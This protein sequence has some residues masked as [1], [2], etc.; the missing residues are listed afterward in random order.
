MKKLFLS[1]LCILNFAGLIA[2]REYKISSATELSALQL[3]AGDKVILANVEWKDQ[4]LILTGNG[5]EASPIV[6]VMEKPGITR[7]TGSS[8]LLIDGTWLQAD[9]LYFTDGYSNKEDVVV[10]SNKSSHC[11]LTNTAI[12]NYFPPDLK[13]DNRWVSLNGQYNRVDHCWLEGKSNQGPTLVVWLA[14]QPNYHRIDHNYFGTRQE[15]GQNGGETIRIGTSGW[16]MHDSYTTVEDNI[17]YHCDGEI[18]AI[19][20]KSCKNTLRNNLFYECKATLTLRHGNDAEVYGNFFI[21]NNKPGTGGIRIIGE[22]HK[23]HDNYLQDLTG[24]NVSAAINI[25]DGLPNP[26][27]TS[28]WQVKNAVI[29]KN[30]IINC[31][32]SFCIGSGKN[33]ERYL[34]ALNTVFDKNVI[35]TTGQALHWMDDS[36]KIQFSNNLIEKATDIPKLPGGFAVYDLKVQKLSNGLYSINGMTPDPFRKK[37]KIGPGWY[38]LPSYFSQVDQ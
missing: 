19:S 14:E 10:F 3:Q 18:E 21:G 1:A 32:Q 33:A 26:V 38:K 6:L 2:A 36:V 30:I 31:A 22:N 4:R 8:T 5:T 28:H 11:R 7:L 24:T 17:F 20:N 13:K 27:P 12:V 25:M 29:S 16:S 35:Y 23:V 34:P 9:G 37:G 15:L